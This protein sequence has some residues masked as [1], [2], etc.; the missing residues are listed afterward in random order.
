MEEQWKTIEGYE[1]YQI[2]S[3]GRVRSKIAR[4][5]IEQDGFY[6]L[7]PIRSENNYLSYTLY[8]P[9]IHKK[10]RF[11]A[12]RLVALSF[13]PNPKNLPHVNH[14]DENKENNN[15]DNLEWCSPLYNN[16]YGTA[17]LR[18]IETLSNPVEQYTP[19]GIY[20]ATYRNPAVAAELLG[21][22]SAECIHMSCKGRFKYQLAYGFYWKYSDFVI[23]SFRQSYD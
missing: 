19:D 9:N 5:R 15:V 4:R 8:D 7:K 21:F 2:S 18:K 1:N 11:L 14:K 6:Y 16:K 22:S 12:H 17:R 20:V 10:K 13:I 23:P 3:L